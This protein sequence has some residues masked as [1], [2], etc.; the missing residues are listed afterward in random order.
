MEIFRKINFF[1]L[2]Q[3]GEI[4]SKDVPSPWNWEHRHSS[5]LLLGLPLMQQHQQLLDMNR[6]LMSESDCVISQTRTLS[7]T[8]LKNS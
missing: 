6:L 3:K 1:E 8:S 5:A 2:L 4:N 7:V